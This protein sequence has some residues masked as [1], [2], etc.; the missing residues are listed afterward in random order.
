MQLFASS[1]LAPHLFVS[2][3]SPRPEPETSIFP[4]V[5]GVFS[6]FINTTLCGALDVPTSCSPNERADAER[7]MEALM[8]LIP[9]AE[10][11]GGLDGFVPVEVTVVDVPETPLVV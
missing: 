10:P 4:I 2:S 5:N 3:K 11:E 7:L 8:A 6:V 1:R 9:P